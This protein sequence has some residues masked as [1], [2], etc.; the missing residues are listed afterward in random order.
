MDRKI[1]FTIDASLDGKS[2]K[3]ILRNHLRASAA[4]LTQLKKVEDGILLSGEPAFVT[5][6]VRAGE[7]LKITIRDE[8]SAIAPVEMPL[9]VLY[10]DE[11][12]I[13]IN[14][15]RNMPT[16]PSR[17]H[18]ED[19][20]A[21]GLM[22]YFSGQ[23]FTFR[24]ITRLDKDTSGVVL[25]AKNPLSAAILVEDM[26]GGRIQKEYL[27]LVNGFP[28]PRTGRIL[29][30]I[31]R[32]EGSIVL[33]CVA[34][35]GKPAETFYET[36]MESGEFALVRLSP[37][38]GRTHQLRVHLSHLGNPIYGDDL[39]GA[40]QTGEST[41]LHCSRISFRHPLT[42]KELNIEA[43]MPEDMNDGFSQFS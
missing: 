32:K 3:H 14:K 41:R 20:L 11:D 13:A 22:G 10:E 5:H 29:A 25:V 33:R 36:L 6:R 38:T 21:N 30:P 9:A 4:I 31:R 2:I 1:E 7:V 40:P 17:N 8:A 15:P 39:Y 23:K 34:P 37:V 26:K 28:N 12:I 42:G 43:T 18:Y 24:V 19:T 16:H 35:D 27:A